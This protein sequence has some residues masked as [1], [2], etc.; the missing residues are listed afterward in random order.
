MPFVLILLSRD[1][2]S[3]QKG[4][5]D[6]NSAYI[7]SVVAFSLLIHFVSTLWF[8]MSLSQCPLSIASFRHVE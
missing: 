8:S 2:L 1:R 7:L 3:S 5:V 4:T 6:N